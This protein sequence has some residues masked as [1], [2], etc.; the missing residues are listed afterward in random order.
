M[1]KCEKVFTKI[2]RVLKEWLDDVKLN[3]L[4]GSLMTFELNW[5]GRKEK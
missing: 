4:M 5:K 2:K 3:E 1:F